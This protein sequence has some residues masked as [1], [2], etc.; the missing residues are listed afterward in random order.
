MQ[1][2]TPCNDWEALPDGDW[3]VKIDNAREPY[4]VANAFTNPNCR[5]IIVGG[6]FHF[7]A[8]NIIAY[9]PFGRYE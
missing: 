8:G 6:M 1:D 5:V 3:L 4:H 7:D 9:A 2:W